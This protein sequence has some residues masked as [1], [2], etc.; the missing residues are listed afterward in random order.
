MSLSVTKDYNSPSRSSSIPAHRKVATF[1]RNP[2]ADEVR[3]WMAGYKRK[4]GRSAI[5]LQRPASK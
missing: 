1:N 5:I 3:E 2:T 4:T